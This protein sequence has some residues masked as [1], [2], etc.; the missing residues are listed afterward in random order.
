ME[1]STPCFDALAGL[2]PYN[3][4]IEMFCWYGVFTESLTKR[5]ST[6]VSDTEKYKGQGPCEQ[7]A[8]TVT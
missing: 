1:L 2:P 3:S 5:P 7:I 6:R 4:F 8:Y